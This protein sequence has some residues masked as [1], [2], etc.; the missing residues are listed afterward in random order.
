MPKIHS[1][2]VMLS[3]SHEISSTYSVSK[4][5]TCKQITFLI[6]IIQV[7]HLATGIINI[8]G[9]N[10]ALNQLE[11]MSL[12]PLRNIV[13]VL[14]RLISYCS[15]NK[16][17]YLARTSLGITNR[18][19]PTVFQFPLHYGIFKLHCVHASSM[20]LSISYTCYLGIAIYLH[21]KW[22]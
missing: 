22:Q 1:Q 19:S 7:C 3:Y 18:F 2:C 11:S 6:L 9:E 12:Y 16:C 5:V 20:R 4:T 10:I 17:K 14:L 15:L 13:S 21:W 8:A